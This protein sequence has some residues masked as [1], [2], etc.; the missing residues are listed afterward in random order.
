MET[1]HQMQQRVREITAAVATAHRCEASTTFP[2]IDYPPTVNAKKLIMFSGLSLNEYPWESLAEE[3]AAY[4]NQ[5]YAGRE[6]AWQSNPE[7]MQVFARLFEAP[8][9]ELAEAIGED[10]PLHWTSSK[11]VR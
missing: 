5:N 8:N 11:F 7:A 1:L 4:H 2:N 9:E 6:A 3:H 10:Y